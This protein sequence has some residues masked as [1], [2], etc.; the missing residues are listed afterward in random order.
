MKALTADGFVAEAEKLG[1]VVS[2][3]T[4][5]QLETY[6]AL[7]AK[8]QKAINLVGPK[9]LAD[10]WR[11]HFLDSAQLVPLLPPK[12]RSIGDFGSGAG[13]PG[14]VL[15]ILTNRS[16]HLI[17]SDQRK[18]A[19]LRQVAAECG[20]ASRVTIHA[21][22]FEEIEPFPI[23]VATARACAPLPELLGIVAPYIGTEG[24]ALFLKGE[25][26]EEELTAAMKLWTMR[27]ERRRSVTESN[28][29]DSLG[30]ILKLT[31]VRPRKAEL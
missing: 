11:R 19:F 24:T 15:G 29:K 20:I 26:V 21:R 2:R 17:D 28:E 6:A 16:V 30:T 8:W 5:Q 12:D 10:P 14:L 9:T 18:C 3:E 31:E 4:R 23:A 25:R 22:R 27:V 7:L 13:F 1:V